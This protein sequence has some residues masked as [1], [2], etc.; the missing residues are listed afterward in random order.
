MCSSCFGQYPQRRHIDFE[1]SWDG[2]VIK[3]GIMGENGEI[4]QRVPVSIDELIVCEDCIEAAA[5]MLGMSKKHADK[6]RE[7]ETRVLQA[8]ERA[9]GLQVHN[10]QMAAAL[11]TK[12][13][14]QR[15]VA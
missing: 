12:P 7:L 2:P 15:V 1:S 10:E 13:Q 14:R 6:L 9:L 8:E 5:K 11:S 3:D 4:S